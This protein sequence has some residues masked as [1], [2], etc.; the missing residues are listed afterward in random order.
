MADAGI[1]VGH[2]PGAC[3]FFAEVE[4]LQARVDYALAD[5]QR[6]VVESTQVPGPI[7]N[8]GIAAALTRAALDFARRS[9]LTVV[10][11]CSY[12][13]AFLQRHPEYRDLQG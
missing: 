8:R 12:T 2:D 5:G 4:G 9:G 3:R 6:M 1:Q 13:A 10:P 7:A 11:A